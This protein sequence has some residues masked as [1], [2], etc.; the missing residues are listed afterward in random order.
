METGS[1]RADFGRTDFGHT[2]K[3]DRD[4][5]PSRSGLGHTQTAAKKARAHQGF[6]ED[7]PQRHSVHEAF[8]G[9]SDTPN[10]PK[11]EIQGTCPTAR[12]VT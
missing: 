8:R 12:I 10:K 3:S 5:V 1:F 6:F 2:K 4:T 11:A 9:V 7:M